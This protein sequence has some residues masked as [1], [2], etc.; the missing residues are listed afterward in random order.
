MAIK[1]S[2]QQAGLKAHNVALSGIS[3]S[4]IIQATPGSRF[5]IDSQAGDINSML[6]S[7]DKLIITGKD[8][9]VIQV[10]HFFG[11]AGKDMKSLTIDDHTSGGKKYILGDEKIYSDGQPVTS[12]TP[13]QLREVVAGHEYYAQQAEAGA[14]NTD[15]EVDPLWVALGLGGV[16]L[17]AGTIALLADDDDDGDDDDS[18][19]NDNGGGDNGGDDNGGDDNGGGGD[20]GGDGNGVVTASALTMDTTNGAALH[21]TTDTPNATVF[22][23]TNGDGQPDYQTSCDANGA[24]NVTCEPHLADQQQVTAWIQKADGSTASTSIVVDFHAPDVV[25]LDVAED[26]SALSGVTEANATV[27]LDINGDGTVD[28]T[29]KA[30]ADGKYSFDLGDANLIAGVSTLVI[31]DAVGNTTTAV[32]PANTAPTILGISDTPDGAIALGDTTTSTSP[33]IHGLGYPGS[34][35]DIL[36]NGEVVAKTTVDEKGNW[37][38]TLQDVPLGENAYTVS[39][40]VCINCTSSTDSENHEVTIHYT[41][42]ENINVVTTDSLIHVV[43][44]DNGIDTTQTITRATPDGGYLIAWAQ[45]ETAGSQYYDIKVNIYDPQGNIVNTLTLGQENTMDGYTT[46]DGLKGLNNFDVAVSPVDGSIT[47]FYT[48]GTPGDLGYTGT[49]A[50]YQRFSADGTEL[51]DGPQMVAA[52]NE[53]G[54]LGGLIDSAL[55]QAISNMVTGVIDKIWEPIEHLLQPVANIFNVNLDG[56]EDLFVNGLS[57]RLASLFYGSGTFGANIIQMDDGSVVFVGT[58]Y[59]ECLDSGTLVDRLDVSGFITDFF[60]DIGLINQGN[61]VSALVEPIFNGVMELLVKPIEHIIDQ[62]LEWLDINLGSAGS[63]VWTVEFTP[64]ENG[65]LVQSTDFQYA[66]VRNILSGLDENGFISGSD[67]NGAINQ[68]AQWIFG[69]NHDD[70]GASQGLDGT[71]VSDTTYAVIWQ[72]AGNNAEL[73]GSEQPQVMMT[74]VDATNGQHITSDITL[75]SSGLAPK[76]VTLADGSLLATWVGVSEA[77]SGDIYSQRLSVVDNKI[78]PLSDAVMVNTQTDGTQGLLEGTFKEAYDVTSLDNGGYVITWSSTATDGTEHLQAQMYDMDGIKIGGEMRIDSGMGNEINDSSVTAL[79]DGGYVV[80]WSETNETDGTS[81]VM[82]SIYNSDGSIRASG[83]ESPTTEG[84]QYVL[85]PEATTFTGSDGSDVVDAHASQITLDS[86]AGDDRI[87]VD[88]GLAQSI[89]GGAGFD[90]VAFTNAGAIGSD[91][92]AKLHHV[93][94]IDLDA[95]ND[96][97]TLTLSYEDVMKVSD[98]GKLF[99]TGGSNDSVDLDQD[100]WTMTATG[101]K[102]CQCYNLY[103]YDDDHHTQVWVQNNVQVI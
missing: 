75:S 58:R 48:E 12:Y 16:A 66:Q 99:I 23:D 28:Y 37:Q 6:R 85:D 69:T 72:K 62:G 8:G 92:L 14:Y 10:D 34:E 15:S 4:T 32:L 46:I 31:T 91:A 1:I 19:N 49:A 73:S 60:T 87:I 102:D 29:I 82:Y 65:N 86:G 2:M 3:N 56:L 45:P 26:L 53:L 89:D 55:G 54:G 77:D 22:I 71:Q 20:N 79:S 50:V 43:E 67:H 36:S 80:N 18:S 52:N 101:N 100:K 35:V 33:T 96:A 7:G 64:D 17:V 27:N 70:V 83:E 94:K 38:V 9:K 40:P 76:I 84:S 95:C 88:S 90:T 57:N 24:W 11:E 103:T 39:T 93:E 74:L 21:G 68:I 78:V 81:T 44:T 51:T 47:V 98:D 41:C 59:S 13:E 5:A 63:L 97:T 61:F 25:S 30:D 42:D